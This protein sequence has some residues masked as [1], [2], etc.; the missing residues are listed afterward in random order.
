[1]E[2]GDGSEHA[3]HADI[4]LVS[5]L[6]QPA[7]DFVEG[8][9]EYEP[10]FRQVVCKFY[11]DRFVYSLRSLANQRLR[12]ALLVVFLHSGEGR[13]HGGHALHHPFRIAALQKRL[14]QFRRP[15][16]A[17]SCGPEAG[18]VFRSTPWRGGSAT[19][20]M[21]LE[22]GVVRSTQPALRCGESDPPEL[23]A[24]RCGDAPAGVE[25]R[26]A[27]C[28]RIAIILNCYPQ[29][30]ETFVAQELWPAAGRPRIRYRFAGKAARPET[31]LAERRDRGRRALRSFFR[32][33]RCRSGL[34]PVA[35]PAGLPGGA[36]R[37]FGDLMRTANPLLFNQFARA[38]I[39][40]DRL[41]ERA[42][43]F[44][45]HFMNKPAAVARMRPR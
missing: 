20:C 21:R 7:I 8:L 4:P 37:F 22:H 45:A 36:P 25:V 43:H 33:W 2:P 44:H 27:A 15:G 26:V 6:R 19:A 1:M 32:C 38:L 41:R 5:G 11:C 29:T 35:Q 12:D 9:T 16:L 24:A 34:A 42:G 23:R 39:V 40:C 3:P 18:G 17:R 13:L 28:G 10:A 30:S 31:K 14:Q